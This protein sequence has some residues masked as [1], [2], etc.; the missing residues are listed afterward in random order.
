MP[1]RDVTRPL[2]GLDR[3]YL[4]YSVPRLLEQC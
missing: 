4:H 1:W 2:E 3:E